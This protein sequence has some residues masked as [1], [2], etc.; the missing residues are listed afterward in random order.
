MSNSYPELVP[1][2]MKQ[3]AEF[4]RECLE[5]DIAETL[6]VTR[7]GESHCFRIKAEKLKDGY[8][9]N[10]AEIS[11]RSFRHFKFY[12]NIK[13]NAVVVYVYSEVAKEA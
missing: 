2:S 10:I 11:Q 1:V 7:C 12:W 4:I 6:Q 9:A 5:C 13:K 3:I 8:L